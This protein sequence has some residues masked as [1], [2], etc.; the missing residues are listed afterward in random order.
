M[1]LVAVRMGMWVK[2]GVRPLR[3]KSFSSPLSISTEEHLRPPKSSQLTMTQSHMTADNTGTV[4]GAVFSRASNLQS[5]EAGEQVQG[6]VEHLHAADGSDPSIF[7][8]GGLLHRMHGH[9]IFHDAVNHV[10][11]ESFYQLLT[12]NN[13]L[14][15]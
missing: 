1:L 3:S 14:Q 9:W 6:H 4:R 10:R 2:C 8:Q 12:F 13:L 11:P 15:I 5:P 7:V